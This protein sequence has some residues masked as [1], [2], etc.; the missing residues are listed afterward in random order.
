MTAR[1]HLPVVYSIVSIR[2]NGDN[3]E[4]T[5]QNCKH[6]YEKLNIRINPDSPNERKIK[7]CIQIIQRMD[8][9]YLY[10]GHMVVNGLIG[11]P[12]NLASI[13][14][15]TKI[16]WKNGLKVHDKLQQIFH[17]QEI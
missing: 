8:V 9:Y 14:E 7:P 11:D 5:L 16:D 2:P 12:I 17:Y 10:Q 3:L 15:N 13:N 6:Q 4:L 1:Y